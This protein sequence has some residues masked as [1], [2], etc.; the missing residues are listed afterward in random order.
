[1]Q[2]P[3]RSGQT[4]L[5]YLIRL[6]LGIGAGAAT[7]VWITPSPIA[8]LV[9]AWYI[10][11]T[12]G[13]LLAL[14]TPNRQDVALIYV[15]PRGIC[16]AIALT[17]SYRM[18]LPWDRVITFSFVATAILE[19]AAHL[20]LRLIR[21]A[22]S[23]RARR[24]VEVASRPPHDGPH[25]MGAGRIA[26]T[27]T[28]AL[29][30]VLAFS[31][32]AYVFIARQ[33]AFDTR[34]YLASL[35][36]SGLYDQLVQLA[37]DTALDAARGSGPGARQVTGALS[38]KDVRTAERLI[39]PG[40]WTLS[41]LD[42]SID[43][44]LSWL[45]TEDGRSV[46]PI[47]LPIEDLQRHIVDAA[48]ILMDQY[49]P[50]LP[51]CTPDMPPRAYCRPQGMGVAAYE[52]TFKPENLAIIDKVFTLIPAE[53][54]LSTAVTMFPDPFRKPLAYLPGAR[55]AVHT[56][57]R[58]LPIAGITCLALFILTWFLAAHTLPSALRWTGATLVVAGL[59][60]WAI[61]QITST[62]ALQAAARWTDDLLT[63]LPPAGM[64]AA[65]RFAQEY[66]NTA[67][68]RLLPWAGVL[69]GLGLLVALVGFLV[70]QADRRARRLTRHQAVGVV[71]LAMAAGSLL[72]ALYLEAGESAY[73]RAAQ[74]DRRG[75]P[76][77]ACALYGQIERYYPLH[78][79]RFVRSAYRGWRACQR[80]L[81]AE[82]AYRSGDYERAVA[83][84]EA[85]LLGNPAIALR[86]EAQAHLL[87]ALLQWGRALEDAGERERALDR[88]RFIRDSALHR[89]GYRTAGAP[90]VRIDEVI[91]GLYLAWG[92]ELLEDDDPQA[93]LATY[94][95]T[96]HDAADPSLWDK[97]EDR[98][99]DAYCA[100]ATQLREQGQPDRAAGVCV[101]FSLEFPST[102]PARCPECPP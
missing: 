30:F 63:R 13:W 66:L 81:D 37:S 50:E 53:L 77:D 35:H 2:R 47:S 78:V 94:R 100:W 23:D 69:A 38:E 88:Y 84:Y 92:D 21:P 86:N 76:A 9:A 70:P 91:A 22:A 58:G 16:T 11:V 97:A 27:A 73:N 90:E 48:S 56:L 95:R 41:W 40:P 79:G 62:F 39:L 14:T 85:F 67:Q 60:A 101:E 51:L 52:A 32:T 6:I 45:E 98:I 26:L 68:A 3:D 64:D 12:V 28:G 15:L 33:V 59:G 99:M 96:L 75:Q 82:S 102:D 71:L 65:L 17:V 44:T 20:L 4:A 54:D 87:D 89:G 74:A 19:G 1:M 24:T 29:L 7:Y 49:V 10:F 46:P 83:L 34:F 43:A 5:F 18:R 57:D 61:G 55:R 8:I 25:R 42:R 93:A 31:P 72:W 36:T 80:Y